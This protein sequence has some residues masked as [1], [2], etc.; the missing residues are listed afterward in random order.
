V[1]GR[2]RLSVVRKDL[3]RAQTRSCAIA[4][5]I[6]PM[7]CE[8]TIAKVNGADEARAVRIDATD[9]PQLL[10]RIEISLEDFAACLMGLGRVPADFRTTRKNTG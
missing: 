6:G 1:R 2:C 8:L 5:R 4:R 10:G 9:G 3:V 7:K